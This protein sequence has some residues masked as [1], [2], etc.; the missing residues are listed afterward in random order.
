MKIG[1]VGCGNMATAMINGIL[2]SNIVKCSDIIVSAKTQKTLDNIKEKFNVNTTIDSKVVCK[3]SDI[4]ILAT[5]PNIYTEILNDIFKSLDN[6]KIIVS[7]AAGKTIKS[8]EDIIGYDKKIIRTMPNTPSLVNEGMSAICKNNNVTS[9]DLN[10]V[11]DIFNSFGKTEVVDESLIDVVIGTSGSS[12]AYIYILIEAMADC[13]VKYGMSRDMAYKF[14]SQAV[15]GSA[16]M[17]LETNIHPG[18]LKD[19][20]CSPGGTTIEAVSKLEETGFRSSIISAMSVA[21]EK[22]INM[23]KV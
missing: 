7:I 19:N 22:S 4:V 15:L 3:N 2:N 20:V 10:K 21:I 12:P 11:L 17:V 18:K 16:K 5:K 1:F 8:I 23:S 14:V 9:G 6:T 13:A